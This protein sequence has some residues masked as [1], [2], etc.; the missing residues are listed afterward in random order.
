MYLT[1]KYRKQL[2]NKT[3]F[4]MFLNRG[5]RPEGF[6]TRNLLYL[7]FLATNLLRLFGFLNLCSLILFNL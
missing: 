1:Y 2:F 3:V 7:V 6:L 4:N 5:G